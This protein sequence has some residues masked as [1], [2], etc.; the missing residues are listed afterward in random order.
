MQ[1]FQGQTAALLEEIKVRLPSM[2][3]SIFQ[4]NF[5]SADLEKTEDFFRRGPMRN[6]ELRQKHQIA[7]PL[8]RQEALED[9][10]IATSN[11][12]EGRS[13]LHDLGGPLNGIKP[14]PSPESSLLEFFAD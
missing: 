2:D 5:V 11:G 14:G 13:E 1:F 6:A 7:S 9:L 3:R 12:L 4:Q 10:I 8:I